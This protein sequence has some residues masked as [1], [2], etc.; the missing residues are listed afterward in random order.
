MFEQG[1]C[2]NS[3]LSLSTFGALRWSR[4]A[5]YGAGAVPKCYQP[6]LPARKNQELISFKVIFLG[7]IDICFKTGVFFLA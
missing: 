4:A 7:L 3:F 5:A 1:G 6:A 2:A